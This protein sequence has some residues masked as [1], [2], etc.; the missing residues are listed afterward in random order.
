MRIELGIKEEC[1]K[2]FI[3]KDFWHSSFMRRVCVWPDVIECVNKYAYFM[4]KN[5]WN[6]CRICVNI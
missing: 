4:Q 6:F 5:D 1:Q 2:S 3:Y